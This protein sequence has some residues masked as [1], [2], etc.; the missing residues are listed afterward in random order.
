MQRGEGNF[1]PSFYSKTWR[2]RLEI[3][4][5]LLTP[6]GVIVLTIGEEKLFVVR[7]LMDE[8]FGVES[9]VS[10]IVFEYSYQSQFPINPNRHKL[11]QRT[12][13]SKLKCFSIVLRC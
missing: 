10:L 6:K 5:E 4:W 1:A 12:E 3:A 11:I 9:Y 8:L 2:L 7:R 13:F